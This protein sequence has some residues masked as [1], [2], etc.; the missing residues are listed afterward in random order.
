MRAPVVDGT[1][2]EKYGALEA[3]PDARFRVRVMSDF[4]SLTQDEDFRRK[5][6][7]A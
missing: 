4:S 6:L 1:G 3:K 7:E 2:S 5:F